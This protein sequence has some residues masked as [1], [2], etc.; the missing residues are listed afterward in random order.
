MSISNRRTDRYDIGRKHNG[1]SKD[2]IHWKHVYMCIG[3]RLKYGAHQPEL[4]WCGMT[5]IG[6]RQLPRPRFV[7]DQDIIVNQG[8]SFS[9]PLAPCYFA[10]LFSPNC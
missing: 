1:Q 3:E 7:L 5:V 4:P 9:S 2:N 6:I 10:L 8:N